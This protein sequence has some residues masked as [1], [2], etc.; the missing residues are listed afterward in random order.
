MRDI[1]QILIY[2]VEAGF[3]STR[4][5]TESDL[6]LISV[7][8]RHCNFVVR[9]PG[10]PSYFIKIGLDEDKM[11]AL[12]HEAAVYRYLASDAS[13]VVK[14]S[15]P[16]FRHFDP[17]HS[18]LILDLISN[19]QTLRDNNFSVGSFLAYQGSELGAALAEL[20]TLTTPHDW[21]VEAPWILSIGEP[22]TKMFWEM[23]S[24]SVQ[25]LRSLQNAPGVILAIETIRSAWKP[26]VLVHCDL[27][28]DNL[29]VSK[30]PAVSTTLI[31]FG[32][33]IGNL[34]AKAIHVGTLGE[35]CTM[36]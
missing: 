17:V 31:T 32:S 25:L 24:A 16:N 36:A 28:C 34:P 27:K 2:L 6:A 9:V 14:R 18:I 4:H 11:S 20:H 21:P 1:R 7:S 3:I 13:A 26:T 15:L 19:C 10:G 35:Y 12:E 29:L 22:T 33:S 8:R 23:S 30:E 5:I